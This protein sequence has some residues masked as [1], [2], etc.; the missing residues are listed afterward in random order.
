MPPSKSERGYA[1]CL[2]F[3][4][5]DLAADRVS[6]GAA[7]GDCVFSAKRVLSSALTNSPPADSLP[8]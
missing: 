1:D 4:M 2:G 6:G 3:G 7:A 8:T 5:A